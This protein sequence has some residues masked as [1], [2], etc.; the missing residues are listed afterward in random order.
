LVEARCTVGAGCLESHLA[1]DAGEIE[2][3]DPPA[4]LTFAPRVLET[5]LEVALEA[6]VRARHGLGPCVASSDGAPSAKTLVA[7]G[8]EVSAAGLSFP[9]RGAPRQ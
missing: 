8:P 7:T 9:Q 3:V 4:I 5:R 6:L 1:R 2:R